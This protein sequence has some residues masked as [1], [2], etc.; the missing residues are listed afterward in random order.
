MV[1]PPYVPKVK[2]EDDVKYIAEN[3]IEEGVESSPDSRILTRQ[4][5]EERYVQ[6]FSFVGD[7]NLLKLEE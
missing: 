1:K 5:K 7:K 4:E 3:W 2:A 6:N